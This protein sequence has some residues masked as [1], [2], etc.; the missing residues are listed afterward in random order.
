M[1]E[2]AVLG[3]F[4]DH[5]KHFIML[6]FQTTARIISDF[7]ENLCALCSKLRLNRGHD[8][9][10]GYFCEKIRF[11]FSWFR[12]HISICVEYAFTFFFFLSEKQKIWRIRWSFVRFSSFVIFVITFDN[13]VPT[14]RQIS[15]PLKR[16]KILICVYRVQ[17]CKV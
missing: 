9:W 11:I 13:F 17:K 1:N 4:L 5:R 7:I 14:F 10:H 8:L 15:N 2:Q 3:S 12:Y 6:S 16:K